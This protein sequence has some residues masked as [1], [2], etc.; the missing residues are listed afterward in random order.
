MELQLD[1][2]P[3]RDA[4]LVEAIL[5]MESEPMDEAALCRVSGLSKEAAQAALEIL[6]ERYAREES[7]LDLSQIGGGVAISPKRDLWERL[8]DRYGKKSEGRISRAAMETLAIIAYSQ[9]VTKAE[10]KA[11]RGVSPDNMIHL[12]LERDLIREAGKK[13][14]PG[15]P[16]QYGTTREFLKHFRMDSIA[17]LPKLSE[18]DIDRFEL[19]GEK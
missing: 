19:E 12:L 6:G 18:G 10:I 8:K 2:C 17:D 7:G 1:E 5:F 11:F 14:V 15:K 9:P 13:D 16:V 4:A 3:Q